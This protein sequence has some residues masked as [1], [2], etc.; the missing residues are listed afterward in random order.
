MIA[1][2]PSDQIVVFLTL[3]QH[4][5]LLEECVAISPELLDKLRFGRVAKDGVLFVLSVDDL[6]RLLDAVAAE[7]NLADSARRRKNLEGVCEQL[8]EAFLGHISSFEQVEGAPAD[9][10]LYKE[11]EKALSKFDIRSH[12]DLQAAA[13][14]VIAQHNLMSMEDMGGL[15]PQQVFDLIHAGWWAKPRPIHLN[16]GLSLSDLDAA[17][18]V[19]NARIFLKAVDEMNGAPATAKGNL[20]R[21]FVSEMLD[22]L[23]LPQGHVQMIQAVNRVINEQDVWPLHLL[24]IVCELGKLVQKQKK[25]FVLTPHAR[26]MIDDDK[27]GEL[28]RHLFETFFREFNL[29]YMDKASE[30]RSVQSTFPYILYR[31]GTLPADE[32]YTVESLVPMVLLPK[33]QAE[34]RAAPLLEHM[35]E[36]MLEARILKPLQGF[37]LITIERVDPHDRKPWLIT[38]QKT[39]LFESFVQLNLGKG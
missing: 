31:L 10:A 12:E 24:R 17:V 23:N 26:D 36:W 3:S 39:P 20:T 5:M 11:L 1:G 16:P 35:T 29:A 13:G 38:V 33:V 14:Q 28:Y 15:S 2:M 6:D 25:Q 27:A 8:R 30:A 32:I 7:A 9:D 4:K 22:R 18:F 21:K 34:I 37:G 19:T